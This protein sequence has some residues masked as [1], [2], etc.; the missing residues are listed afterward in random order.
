MSSIIAPNADKK[1]SYEGFECVFEYM[2]PNFRFHL[3]QK[4]PAIRS[5][6][7]A[8]P[9]QISKLSFS[10][11][12]FTINDTEYCLGV[13]CE[14]REGPTPEKLKWENERGGFDMDVDEYGFEDPFEEFQ[15]TSGDILVKKWF[16]RRPKSLELVEKS[17]EK[18]EKE[19]WDLEDEKSELEA[20]IKKRESI[21]E[22]AAKN[23]KDL[24]EG[25][26][27]RNKRIWK[28]RRIIQLDNTITD[29]KRRLDN[30][31]V[32]LAYHRL[33]RNELPSPL[34]IYIQLTRTSPDGTVYTERVQ[35]NKWF[36]EA[37]RYLTTKFLG[38]RVLAPKVKTLRFWAEHYQSLVIPLPN[39]L[40]LDVEEF[41]TCGDISDVLERVETILEHPKRPFAR[42]KSGNLELKDVQHPKVRSAGVL[43][44]SY[45][46]INVDWVQL[47]SALPNKKIVID[48][49]QTMFSTQYG[50]L[51]QNIIDKKATL[52]TCYQ[53]YSHED[54]A[55]RVLKDVGRR[56]ENAVV[57]E[58]LV[59][60]PLPY[61]L[62][63]D[64][65]HGRNEDPQLPYRDWFVKM[66][67]VQT[68]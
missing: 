25:R 36:N 28:E 54:K 64:V 59:S 60:I 32:E 20:S 18:Y 57:G 34:D 47:C 4:L 13:I 26:N 19:L 50:E 65:S 52:G 42:L 15:L 22:A 39:K 17:V 43:I 48:H 63:L 23:Q 62:Q 24:P 1:L 67:V 38:N 51:V 9:L 58:R 12:G 40:K 56:F 68:N 21:R 3:A 46:G 29:T 8:F 33:E 44:L 30:E 5:I 35:Y 7:K 6:E 66:E 41:E 2:E 53:I 55:R 61:L 11:T 31:R 14:A 37:R 45:V 10:R 49:D 16:A 27:A